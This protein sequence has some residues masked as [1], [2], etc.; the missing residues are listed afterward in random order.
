VGV[1]AFVSGF[2]SFAGDF[3][4]A[5]RIHRGKTAFRFAAGLAAGVAWFCA[6]ACLSAALIARSHLDCFLEKNAWNG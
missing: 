2:A 3:P 1:T 5:L 4:L 6:W